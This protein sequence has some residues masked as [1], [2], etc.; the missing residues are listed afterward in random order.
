MSVRWKDRQELA[1]V[2]YLFSL[3]SDLSF[4][5]QGQI[6]GADSVPDLQTA[7]SKVLRIS[8]ETPTLALEP[9][10]MATTR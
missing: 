1:V 9:S 8:T 6:L 4:Q 10:A 2:I 3:N 5:I 7:F